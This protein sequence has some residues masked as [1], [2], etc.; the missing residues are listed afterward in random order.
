MAFCTS[1]AVEFSGLQWESGRFLLELRHFHA[2]WHQTFRQYDRTPCDRRAWLRRDKR[3]RPEGLTVLLR[4][5]GGRN[6]DEGARALEA[7]IRFGESDD[8]DL[9]L[10]LEGQMPRETL[11][12]RERAARVDHLLLARFQEAQESAPSEQNQSLYAMFA[13]NLANMLSDLGRREEALAQ[14]EEAVRIR[15]E[16]AGQRPDAFLPD[17]A[18]S[19]AVLGSVIA[20]ERPEEAIVSFAEAV[21]ILSP[22][23]AARPQAHLR[24]MQTI[25]RWYLQAVEAAGLAPDIDLLAPVVAVF[26]KLNPSGLV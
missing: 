6:A 2:A 5:F 10:E 7:F 11:V 17:L 26:E 3:G 8:L 20:A 21:R 4:V 15:R 24:L 18:K 12:L 25:H 13:N 1:T 19:L 9:L 22:F 14:A 16:L 23:F